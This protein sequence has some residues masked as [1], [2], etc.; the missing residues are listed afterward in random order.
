M[1]R[2]KSEIFPVWKPRKSHFV[3]SETI[4]KEDFVSYIRNSSY[5]FIKRADVRNYI[6]KR[7]NYKCVTCGCE[8]NLHIDHIKRISSVKLNDYREYNKENSLQTLCN[9]CNARKSL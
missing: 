9:S 2:P 4:N 6:F 3:L 1:A 5:A 7:D 8:K